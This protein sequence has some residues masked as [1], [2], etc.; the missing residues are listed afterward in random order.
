MHG[1]GFFYI[2]VCNHIKSIIKHTEESLS[3]KP[4]VDF[5]RFIHSYS[6]IKSIV[7]LTDKE[8]GFLVFITI[9]FNSGFMCFT[10]YVTL[11]FNITAGIQ[12]V[13][14]YG[15]F[16]GALGLFI[17]MTVS[18][19]MVAD[20][21]KELCSA[22]PENTGKLTFKQ[23]R[24]LMTTQNGIT[25]TVWRIVPITRSFIFVIIGILLTYT[26]MFSSLSPMK[27]SNEIFIYFEQ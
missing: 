6:R 2:A 15:M 14:I 11:N 7:D 1:F 17:G 20:E 22:M 12:T 23:I 26:V 27:G 10:F 25:L 4:L 13:A 16:F 3:R 21:S 5:E 8:V 18:A 19:S 24:F 9:F